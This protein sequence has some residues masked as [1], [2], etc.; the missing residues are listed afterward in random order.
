MNESIHIV[1]YHSPRGSYWECVALPPVWGIATRQMSWQLLVWS[2]HASYQAYNILCSAIFW[3]SKGIV[4]LEILPLKI[5]FYVQAFPDIFLCID[6]NSFVHYQWTSLTLLQFIQI[7]DQTSKGC[8]HAVALL[9]RK[10]PV[11]AD[12]Y[13]QITN[14]DYGN[15]HKTWNYII[16]NDKLRYLTDWMS[17]WKYK[18]HEN[19]GKGTSILIVY[20]TWFAKTWHNRTYME[21]NFLR[22]CV[23]CIKSFV[24]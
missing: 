22:H 20:V 12:E 5:Y 17:M 19:S 24:L 15:I 3:R 6:H 4:N 13:H 8:M 21:I 11:V 18:S 9:L 7:Y 16:F 1:A 10:W 14:Y 23:L 2:M